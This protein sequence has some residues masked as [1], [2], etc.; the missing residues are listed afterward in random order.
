MEKENQTVAVLG[1]SQKPDRYS[2]KAIRLLLGHGHAVVPVHPAIDRVENLAVRKSLQEIDGPVDTLT[3]YVSAKL[4]TPLSKEI[5]LLN[6]GRV[7]FNPGTENPELYA[8]LDE[9]GISYEEACTL[10]LL[11][12]GQF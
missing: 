7:I 6:P 12:S 4:S 2:N 1:A 5:L 8:R 3:V 11:H 9:A 10:V